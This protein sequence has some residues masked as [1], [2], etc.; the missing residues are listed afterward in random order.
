MK[1]KQRVG[2]TLAAMAVSMFVLIGM[3]SGIRPLS[4]VRNAVIRQN[5]EGALIENAHGKHNDLVQDVHSMRRQLGKS[6]SG[7]GSP[8]KD[9]DTSAKNKQLSPEDT[10]TQSLQN[11]TRDGD[12]IAIPLDENNSRND[13]EVLVEPV[14]KKPDL[15]AQSLL[16]VLGKFHERTPLPKVRKPY[17]GKFDDLFATGPISN[18]TPKDADLLLKPYRTFRKVPAWEQ[19]QN[20]INRYGL[21]NHNSDVIPELLNNLANQEIAEVDEKNGGT[22]VKLIID[23]VDGGQALFKPWKVPRDY[24]TIPDH[25]YFSD[26]ERH[27]AEIAAFHLDRILDFRRA[28]PQV[29]RWLNMTTEIYD[30]A[31]SSLRKTFFRSPANNLCF[32]GHCSYYCQTET[33]VCGHPDMI[34]G[35]FAAYLPPFKMAPRKTWRHPWRRSYSKHRKAIWEDD[36]DY[37]QEVRTK[38]PYNT[39][40]RLLDLMDLAVFDFLTGNMDRH[41]YETFEKFG[42]FTFPIHLDQGRSFG[43]HAHDE[44]SILV[45]IVHCCLMRKSTYQR[46]QL[47]ATDRYR[48]SDVMRDSMY[49]DKIAPVL[50]EPHYDAL[51]RRL[52]IILRTVDHC[53]TQR[54]SSAVLRTEPLIQ[55]YKE[56]TSR[57]QAWFW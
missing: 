38:H 30:L 6:D 48:L 2:V 31:D 23:Y 57:N 34:E 20:G 56:P 54:G 43:K 50:F 32:V 36:P 49:H 27:N 1:L 42:N 4:A 41:H 29:G 7:P 35:S 15:Y 25:F 55:S 44:M 39:G 5:E 53:I 10:E 37:C 18:P 40:R 8:V 13:T 14:A 19:F 52:L 12:N 16:S 45:P 33:A 11:R 21:Y 22:Q 46:L 51:D 26:I 47:L 3:E 17:T 28:P 9:V 24:Q